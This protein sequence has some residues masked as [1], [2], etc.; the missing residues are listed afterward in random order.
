MAV[1]AK[2]LMMI[3]LACMLAMMM[4]M[5][6]LGDYIVR[7]NISFGLACERLSTEKAKTVVCW[8]RTNLEE[9]LV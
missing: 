9:M 5:M 7:L 8:R 3:D 4:V 1:T 2:R 6:L